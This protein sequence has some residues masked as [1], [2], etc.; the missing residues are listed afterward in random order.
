MPA[1]DS[2]GPPHDLA[3]LIEVLDRHSVDYLLA[4][5]AAAR[6]YG[7][8]RLTEDADCVVRRERPNL[9]RLA[10]A[11]REL[12]ARLR[13]SGMSDDDARQLP[14]QLDGNMLASADISTWMT[15]AGGF[16]VL[17]GL[18]GADG[19]LVPYEDLARRQTIIR[20]AGFT[21]RAAA[22]E[23]IITAKERAGRPK[24]HDALPE[25]R[26]LRDART[27]EERCPTPPDVGGG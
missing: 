15:D 13:V 10:S 7:A 26:A 19:L 11:M 16:D 24:D 2:S 12:N 6:A 4:G 18:V 17:P 23:D 5:G 27:T 14:V 3:R 1:P 21:I 9:D 25:L 20:G 22:L 8:E